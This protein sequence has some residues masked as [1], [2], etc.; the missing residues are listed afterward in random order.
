[1]NKEMNVLVL[2]YLGDT[3]YEYYIRRYLIDSGIRNVKD[4]QAAS[5][6][7]VSAKSQCNFLMKLLELDFFNEEEIAIIYRARNNKC[8]RH[9]KNC[10]VMTYKYATALESVIGYLKLE[11]KEERIEKLLNY[12]VGGK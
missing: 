2:A 7:Y 6:N 1:M 3:V 10:D 11:E 4:L 8:S 9:P 12:I 5:I